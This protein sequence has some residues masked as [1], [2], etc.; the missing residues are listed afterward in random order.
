MNIAEN[1]LRLTNKRLEE[2]SSELGY[3]DVANFSKAFSQL[4]GITPDA[5]RKK[6]GIKKAR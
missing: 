6:Y 1:E 3:Q 2:I 5:F 4:K